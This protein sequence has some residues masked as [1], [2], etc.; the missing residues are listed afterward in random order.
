M[1][2]K[3]R[4]FIIFYTAIRTAPSLAPQPCRPTPVRGRRMPSPS[5]RA[6]LQTEAGRRGQQAHSHR[7]SKQSQHTVP[8]NS[9]STPPGDSSRSPGNLESARGRGGWR[10]DGG[11]WTVDGGWWMVDGGWWM[12]DGGWW[13]SAWIKLTGREWYVRASSEARGGFGC[14]R[15]RDQERRERFAPG[16]F[17][18]LGLEDQERPHPGTGDRGLGLHPGNLVRTH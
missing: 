3:D 13:M 9:H 8:A 12:A 4:Y 14:A 10:V 17:V 1:R 15:K 18:V 16:L 7:Q 2:G 5:G 11:R 6:W